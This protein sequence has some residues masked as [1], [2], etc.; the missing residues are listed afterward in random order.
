[1]LVSTFSSVATILPGGQTSP[2]T[3]QKE[4]VPCPVCV[5]HQRHGRTV[6]AYEASSVGC[7]L[8]CHS[9]L[10]NDIKITNHHKDKIKAKIY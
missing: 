2:A 10:C 1:M 8:E 4:A 7:D 9:F 6:N 5:R 3:F